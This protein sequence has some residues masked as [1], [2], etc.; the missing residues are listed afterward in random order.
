MK[1][2][3]ILFIVLALAIVLSFVSDYQFSTEAASTGWK[4]TSNGWMYVQKN[5][6]Y[7]KNRWF[8]VS[9]K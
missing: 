7:V 6:T 5:G 2:R 8:K 9:D 1:K 4:K 3:K